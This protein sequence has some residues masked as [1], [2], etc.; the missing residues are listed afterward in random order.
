MVNPPGRSGLASF[1]EQVWQALRER[2][3]AHALELH[4][5]SRRFVIGG[6]AAL[7]LTK[8][9]RAAST[10]GIGA[11]ALALGVLLVAWG[12]V[13]IIGLKSEPKA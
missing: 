10:I 5:Q 4:P 11:F 12:I 13:G 9:P 3:Q 1:S 8:C 2:H 7:F 6:L